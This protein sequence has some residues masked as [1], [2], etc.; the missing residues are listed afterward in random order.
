MA[1]K[2][3]RHPVLPVALRPT[4]QRV[5]VNAGL[6]LHADPWR[7]VCEFCPHAECILPEGGISYEKHRQLYSACPIVSA[8]DR[9]ETLAEILVNLQGDTNE[10]IHRPNPPLF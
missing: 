10:Q 3:T 7:A 5:N 8:Q 4:R 1:L 6:H 2:A 9:G